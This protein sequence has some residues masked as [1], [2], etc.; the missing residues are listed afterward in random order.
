MPNCYPDSEIRNLHVVVDIFATA[1]AS[2]ILPSLL[3]EYALIS[4]AFPEDLDAK[5][6]KSGLTVK[7]ILE[8][9]SETTDRQCYPLYTGDNLLSGSTLHAEVPGLTA[10]QTIEAVNWE[11]DVVL[12]Q[13][14]YGRVK[15]LLKKLLP[16]G[17]RRKRVQFKDKVGGHARISFNFVPSNSKFINPYTFLGLMIKVPQVSAVNSAIQR[18]QDQMALITETTV[19]T[20]VLWFV[21]SVRFNERNPDFHMGKV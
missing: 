10:G 4:C 1:D 11:T 17:I 20:D 15:G 7:A 16:I 19:D 8:L 2:A 3:F 18:D 5:D 9:Q 13:M 12:D 6:E 14:R 21:W